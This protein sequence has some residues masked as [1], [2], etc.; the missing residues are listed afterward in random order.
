MQG[1]DDWVWFTKI[2]TN[3][4]VDLFYNAKVFG[5]PA[6]D[7]VG[8]WLSYWPIGNSLYHGDEVN[9]DIVVMKGLVIKGCG[10][11]L[12]YTDEE[13]ES[14]SVENSNESIV[15]AND[16][17]EDNKFFEA[18]N[19][20]FEDN[21]GHDNILG[22]DISEFRLSTGTY[23]LCRR[24]YSCLM[25]VGRLSSNWFKNLVGDTVDYT[26]IGGWRK[27]GR[28]DQPYQSFRELKTVGC[29]IY[30]P[31]LD[32]HS[33]SW[34]ANEDIGKGEKMDRERFTETC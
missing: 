26:E 19:N 29:I 24:D 3:N 9:V 8:I 7:E 16:F 2:R 12:V 27:T 10:A 25:E 15:D 31:Q 5:R 21:I 32:F 20:S 14:D 17:F 30:G 4:G 1:D 11:S 22:V 34:A 6:S 33:L 28:P 13:D 23:Y 18:N